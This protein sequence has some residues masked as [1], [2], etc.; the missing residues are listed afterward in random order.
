[1]E[2]Q[3]S[4]GKIL[5]QTS[6]LTAPDPRR[7]VNPQQLQALSSSAELGLGDYW[8]ILVK[9]KWTIIT[10]VIVILTAALI[11]SWRMTPIY[12]GVARI[13]WSRQMPNFFKDDASQGSVENG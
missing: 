4:S 1:M 10:F 6:E 2:I 11:V 3:M 7:G 12:D 9:R 8:R 5:D 13:N